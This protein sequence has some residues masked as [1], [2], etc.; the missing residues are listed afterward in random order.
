MDLILNQTSLL[1]PS[2]P[3]VLP[4]AAPPID[5]PVSPQ[6]LAP[7]VNPVTDQTPPLPFRCSDWVRAPPAHLRGYFIYLFFYFFNCDFSS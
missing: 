7:P 2:A 5:S 1:P 3:H 4:F 6:K